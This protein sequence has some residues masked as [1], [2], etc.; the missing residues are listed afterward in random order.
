MLCSGRETNG[1]LEL[2][3]AFER[4]YAA[5]KKAGLEVMITTSHSAPYSAKS[6]EVRIAFVE[7]W[8]KSPDVTYLSPQLYTSGGE[9]SPEFEPSS[10]TS[11]G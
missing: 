6:D 11:G 4:T 7:S 1:G 3:E 2:V 10:G 8:I 9:G 5:L